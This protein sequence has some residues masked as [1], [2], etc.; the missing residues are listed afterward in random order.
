MPDADQIRTS[1]PR[2]YRKLF[3]DLSD[4][5][6]PSDTLI[7]VLIGTMRDDIRARGDI[8]LKA[9]NLF[10]MLFSQVQRM[11]LLFSGEASVRVFDDIRKNLIVLSSNGDVDKNTLGLLEQ[12][13]YR[14]FELSLSHTRMSSAQVFARSFAVEVYRAGVEGNL[15]LALKP[16]VAA[17]HLRQI[18]E[19]VVNYSERLGDQLTR[20]EHIR[21]LRLPPNTRAK[22]TPGLNDA[23][24]LGDGA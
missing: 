1:I 4:E 22:L 18:K 11:P 12:A 17:N 3:Q 23:L 8:V 21:E 9:V 19:Q 5:S 15:H 14:T 6:S 2:Q 13:A 16:D 7:S 20:I 10:G 24:P